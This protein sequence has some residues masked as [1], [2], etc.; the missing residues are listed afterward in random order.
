[1]WYSRWLALLVV[2]ATVVSS[3]V[4]ATAQ[5]RPNI[6]WITSEDNSAHWLG[7]YGNKQAQ[8]PRIDRFAKQGIVF[9]HAYSN[10]PVCAVARSTLLTGVYA[11][12]QGTQHMRSRH[13]IPD[14]FRPYVSYLREA[15]YY[16]TNNSKTDY[17]FRGKDASYWDESSGRAHYRNR[18]QGQPFFAIFNFTVSHESSLFADVI[19]R[20]RKQKLIPTE[21][22]LSTDEVDVP[23]LYPDLPEFRR[24]IAVYHDNLSA[25]DR[26]VGNLLD[27]LEADGLA[28]DTI[29]FYYSDHGGI[30][31]RSKRY[32]HDTGTRVPMIVR[33]PPKWQHLTNMESPS[34]TDEL[35]AFID[36]APT[37]LSLAG[38]DI[39]D[40]MQGRAVF[41]AQRSRPDG[42][43]FLFSDRFD[44]ASGMNRGVTDGEFRY[45]H[46]FY[47]HLPA[48]KQNSYPFG[49]A[50]WRAWRKGAEAGT[51]ATRFEQL[52]QTNQPAA[53]LFHTAVDPWEVNSLAANPEFGEREQQ[54]RKALRDKMIEVRDLGVIPEAMWAELT[55]DDNMWAYA[56][57]AKLDWSEL[58]DAAFLASEARGE[59]L[60]LL[61]E[62]LGSESPAIRYWGAIGCLSLGKQAATARAALE[63]LLTDVHSANRTT[64]AH[65]LYVIEPDHRFIKTIVAET[66]IKG[67][68][69][70]VAHACHALYQLDAEDYLTP[71][72]VSKI[73]DGRGEYAKR[74]SERFESHDR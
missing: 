29:V 24:D 73:G 64:A 18:E 42:K 10:A 59:N 7:C 19:A 3:S 61:V 6:L 55:D 28:D 50:S 9:N 54:L 56:E 70:A 69:P 62:M 52:W 1:M 47:P 44:E 16:C 31:P 33:I 58:V 21:P 11:V 32:L 68:D 65:A 2:A 41:G 26:Q 37:L 22:R 34:R 45:I 72:D 12:T 46:N 60:P 39:P 4:V 51:L 25:L 5:E 63:L 35:V 40:H 13:A 67:N 17:N 49:I 8:T 27:Q 36:L 30:L 57:R 71:Q 20:N 23:P 14:A 38:V 15:G 53:E 48:A 74:W 43:V 66:Q